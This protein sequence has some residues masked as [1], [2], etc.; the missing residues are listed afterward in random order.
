MPWWGW[1]L[2]IVAAVAIGGLAG[3]AAILLYIGRGLFG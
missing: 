3:A 1:A 2:V